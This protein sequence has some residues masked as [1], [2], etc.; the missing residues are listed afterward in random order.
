MYDK[1]L[2]RE[3]L[4]QIFN[5]LNTV[6]DRFSPVESVEEFT[7]SP[8]GMEKLD[9]ICM[10]LIAVGEGLKKSIKLQ[11]IHCCQPTQRST[12]KGPRQCVILSAT[13]I[14]TLMRM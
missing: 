10:Q 1:D 5:A 7:D 14:L 9:G 12:G 13:T 2:A 4:S 11:I 8:E 6:L 3:I